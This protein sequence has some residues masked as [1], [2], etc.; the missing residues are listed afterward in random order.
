MPPAVPRAQ[1]PRPPDPNRQLREHRAR[2]SSAL[3]GRHAREHRSFLR[4]LL[5]LGIVVLLISLYRAGIH[6]AFVPGWWREW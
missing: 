2:Q 5:F 6:R 4:G 1:P 3:E